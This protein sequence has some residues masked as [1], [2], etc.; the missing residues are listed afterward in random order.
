MTVQYRGDFENS[1][2]WNTAANNNPKE[3]FWFRNPGQIIRATATL[4]NTSMSSTSYNLNDQS[5]NKSWNVIISPPTYQQQPGT[6]PG[7]GTAVPTPGIGGVTHYKADKPFQ[8]TS[9]FP[10]TG[11]FYTSGYQ[12]PLMVLIPPVEQWGNNTT[13]ITAPQGGSAGHQYHYVNVYV[14]G[15]RLADGTADYNDVR[16][17]E[18]LGSVRLRIGTGTSTFG[19][20]FF[21]YNYYS[22]RVPGTPY[23]Y[24]RIQLSANTVYRLD[25]RTRLSGTVYGWGS[26]VSYA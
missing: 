5:D 21:D 10:T 22:N 24:A 6:I 26:A 2:T 15:P 20:D 23:F 12:D 13:F 18:V 7:P 4:D 25:G 9:Y 14:E 8:L 16:V 17:Q 1:S 19:L 11:V 3:A